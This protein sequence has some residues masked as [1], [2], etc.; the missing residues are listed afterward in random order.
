[1]GFRI[2]LDLIKAE[3]K[4][5]DS[6]RRDVGELSEELQRKIEANVPFEKVRSN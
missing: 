3:E 5:L 2:I 6:W 4:K 1:M